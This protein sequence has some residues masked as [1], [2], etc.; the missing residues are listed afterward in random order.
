M[1]GWMCRHADCC[2]SG[3]TP[4]STAL[5]GVHPD[6]P[7]PTSSHQVSSAWPSPSQW[8]TFLTPKT[9][10]SSSCAPIAPYSQLSN[11]YG[12]SSTSCIYWGL[13]QLYCPYHGG[14]CSCFGCCFH[15]TVCSLGGN[16]SQLALNLP[17]SLLLL[18]VLI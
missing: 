3:L 4:Y 14:S 8:M 11:D 9:R 6:D 7:P 16:H 18:F 12:D 2:T 13:S 1:I 5:V 17:S 10:H 15:L